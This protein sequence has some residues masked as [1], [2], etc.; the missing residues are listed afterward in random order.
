MKISFWNIRDI[1]NS[2]SQTALHDYFRNHRPKIMFI[3]EPKVPF[4]HLTA[5][6]CN[7]IQITGYCMNN[8]AALFSQDFF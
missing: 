4:P 8:R 5:W 6:Y 3:A 7:S 1:E 2:E